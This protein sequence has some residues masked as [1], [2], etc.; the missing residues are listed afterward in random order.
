[1]L[2]KNYSE[3][4]DQDI[5]LSF[6][7]RGWRKS[8]SFEF[9]GE[10]KASDKGSEEH[11]LPERIAVIVGRNGS[12]KSTLLARLA[13]VAHASERERKKDP[14]RKLGKLS[15]HGVGFTRIITISYSAF[16]SFQIPGVTVEERRQI[17]LDVSEGTGRYI[18]CG[19]RDI[20]SELQSQLGEKSNVDLERVVDSDDLTSKTMLKTVDQLASEFERT[21]L[22]IK[23]NKR[24]GVFEKSLKPLI[25]DSSFYGLGEGSLDD[26]FGEDVVSKFL[27]W[28]TGHKI[29]MQIISALVAYTQPKSIVLLDE[30]ET[31]LHPP[32]LAALMH[33]IRFILVKFD[34]C[35][36]LATHSPVVAQETLSRD[37][38]ILRRNDD[39]I[40][41]KAPKIETFGE[42]IGEITNEIFG[43]NSNVTDYYE[44]L[45]R[46]AREFKTLKKVDQQFEF[47]LSL[48]ARAYVLSVLAMEED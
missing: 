23:S 3:L 17:A 38:S 33:S 41:I 26:F 37:I 39:E 43:L 30:P 48:Q 16:D 18:F 10:T 44:V 11:K 29:V 1:M 13:R 42:S 28:S 25:A 15:P 47:G 24:W 2:S 8:F 35:A 32:M 6:K 19:L 12:G 46:L 14:I 40:T 31:H 34:A 27:R 20:A 21:L 9:D 5:K 4:F 45:N 22:R 36:V 7:P